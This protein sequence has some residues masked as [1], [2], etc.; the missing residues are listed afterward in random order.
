[1]QECRHLFKIVYLYR[2]LTIVLDLVHGTASVRVN[3]NNIL[4]TGRISAFL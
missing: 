2:Y 4:E 3:Y 1:M